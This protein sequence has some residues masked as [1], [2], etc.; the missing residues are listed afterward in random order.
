MSRF[1]QV[2]LL[3]TAVT[4]LNGCFLFKA[5]K[6]HAP[7]DLSP[8]LGANV[9]VRVLNLPGL[10]LDKK[11]S[12]RFMVV[13]V[14]HPAVGAMVTRGDA[15][16]LLDA[17]LDNVLCPVDLGGDFA[18]GAFAVDG[19]D[20]VFVLHHHG[21][22]SFVSRVDPST[23]AVAWTS[24]GGIHTTFTTVA[25]NLMGMNSTLTVEA[26]RTTYMA[27]AVDGAAAIQLL[28]LTEVKGDSLNR[29]ER[30]DANTGA[31]LADEQFHARRSLGTIAELLVDF[32]DSRLLLF[33]R[34]DGS[35]MFETRFGESDVLHDADKVPPVDRW[36]GAKP[37]NFFWDLYPVIV[38]DDLLVSSRHVFHDD[39]LGGGNFDGQWAR[40]ALQSGEM[41][42]T[43]LLKASL[44]YSLRSAGED[45]FPILMPVFRKQM[46]ARA[47]YGFP[48]ES[49]TALSEDGTF[50]EV[51]LPGPCATDKKK[52]QC[53]YFWGM[54]FRDGDQVYAMVK[55]TLHGVDTSTGQSRTLFE[56]P[57]GRKGLPQYYFV[58]HVAPGY[59][60]L[61]GQEDAVVVRLSD[62]AEVNPGSIAE[63]KG[64][65]LQRAY[66][67]H[68]SELSRTGLPEDVKEYAGGDGAETETHLLVP[69]L[70][71]DGAAILVG[72]DVRELQPSFWFP[73]GR[74]QDDTAND[75]HYWTRASED[76]LVIVTAQG[77]SSLKVYR[78]RP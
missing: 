72:L 53:S 16:F 1:V 35:Q 55:G 30:I 73:I 19:I 41:K 37:S 59:A 46:R 5:N 17:D 74:V 71:R 78:V 63:L 8:E 13:E 10:E 76:G 3:C 57:D 52:E 29:L 12:R 4:L 77:D 32:D 31:V 60:M 9:S 28:G 24:D 33:N 48:I 65:R 18:T 54:W 49:M 45:V 43:K 27:H 11:S 6:Y 14:D 15:S 20:A 64:T 38:G 70:L 75:F 61:Q 47:S 22:T 50:T 56:S 69:A 68:D 7:P 67:E 51:P 34:M 36:D 25:T 40:I 66:T 21:D 26:H 2:V 42:P 44:D 23:G 58:P 39:I 62:G